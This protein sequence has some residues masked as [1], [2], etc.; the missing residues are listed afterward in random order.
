MRPIASVLAPLA[1]SILL[2]GCGK[3]APQ[4]AGA[5]PPAQP[6][7]PSVTTPE[8][9]AGTTDLL[10]VA[11]SAPKG[12]LNGR[13]AFERDT[14][15]YV[16]WP[17]G[18]G[19]KALTTTMNQNEL[20][21]AW[22]AAGTQ[23]AFWQASVA[24]GPGSIWTMNS[25]GTRQRRLTTGIDA[26]DPVW[27]P[28]GTRIAFTMVD[29][30]GF[31]LWTMRASDGADRR[32]ITSGP[33]LDFEPAWSPDGTRLAFTRGLEEGDPGDIYVINLETAKIAQLTHSP[34]YDLDVAWSPDSTRIVF[35]RE[36][37]GS[38]SIQMIDADGSRETGLTSGTYYDT[39]P[40]FS[41]DGR[42]IAF[43]RYRE[44]V[45]PGDLWT[46]TADGQQLHSILQSL[47]TEGFPDW[48]PLRGAIP[49]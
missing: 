38:A 41:P 1:M 42:Y 17:N 18:S 44:G 13:L 40:T 9:S 49:R 35:E 46:M 21:P 6:G 8:A 20:G 7:T 16:I 36:S 45:I 27:N 10:P 28:D 11:D 2:A 23:I 33:G 48:Q 30:S 34:A 39:G 12:V 32:Q 3:T 31:H 19:L 24:G 26:R 4:S 25:D 29:P 5:D 37:G 22:N 47:V 14:D 43:G 15:I